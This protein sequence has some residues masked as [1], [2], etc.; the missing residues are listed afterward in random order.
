MKE[1]FFFPLK[2]RLLFFSK[3]LLLSFIVLIHSQSF[4]YKACDSRLS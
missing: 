4:H 1:N 3:R 2:T